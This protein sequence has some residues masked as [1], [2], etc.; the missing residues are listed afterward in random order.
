MNI[1][2]INSQINSLELKSG[3]NRT[4]FE[5]KI[6][7]AAK[8]GNLSKE[9]FQSLKKDLIKGSGDLKLVLSELTSEVNRIFSDGASG[10]NPSNMKNAENFLKTIL[11]SGKEI[12]STSSVKVGKEYS[13]EFSG[14]IPD[15]SDKPVI[16]IDQ[17]K[18]STAG[19]SS[20]YDISSVLSD[21]D[22]ENFN[23]VP[24]GK[25]YI[26]IGIGDTPDQSKMNG[27]TTSSAHHGEHLSGN[28]SVDKKDISHQLN[29]ISNHAV[30]YESFTFKKS[31]LLKAVGDDMRLSEKECKE[32]GIP[33]EFIDVMFDSSAFTPLNSLI[34]NSDAEYITITK[35]QAHEITPKD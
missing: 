23:A 10:I 4:Q 25:P 16:I 19:K 5:A 29:S 20:S 6:V 21:F 11:S 17:L 9:E 30:S 27:L 3:V 24:T 8:D 18:Q 35:T 28:L 33:K 32:L 31:D 13:S 2:K 15:K 1:G 34:K 22:S 12:A 14:S 26:A 7:E